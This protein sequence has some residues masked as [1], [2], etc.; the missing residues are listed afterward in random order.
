MRRLATG[1]GIGVAIVV[2]GVTGA[3]AACSFERTRDANPDTGTRGLITARVN[4]NTNCLAPIRP[5]GGAV[6]KGVSITSR[7]KNGALSLPGQ[8]SWDYVP[9]RDFRGEDTFAVR[10]CY[11]LRGVSACSDWEYR[12][13]VQ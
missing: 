1:F 7:P 3:L 2:F 9:H 4:A 12:V 11:D 10:Y 13:I 8:V 6:L 5:A